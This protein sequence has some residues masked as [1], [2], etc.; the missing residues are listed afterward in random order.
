MPEVKKLSRKK[1]RCK[2]QNNQGPWTFGGQRGTR[3]GGKI[4]KLNT[5]RDWKPGNNQGKTQREQRADRGGG[6][7][8]GGS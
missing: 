3:E 5:A 4:G 2:H 8:K 6:E 7:K 1:K